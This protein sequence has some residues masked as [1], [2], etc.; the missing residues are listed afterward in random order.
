MFNRWIEADLLRVLE[1]E[2][3]GCI[4]FS[5]LAKGLLTDRYL[6]GIPAGSRASKPYSYLRPEAITEDR[7]GE[8]QGSERDR[9]NARPEPGPDGTCVEPAA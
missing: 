6:G 9:R 3:V 2:G 5:P 1:E 7:A 4:V 8:G